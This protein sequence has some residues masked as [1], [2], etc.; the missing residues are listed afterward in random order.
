MAKHFHCPIND[1]ECPYFK[2]EPENNHRCICSLPD[3]MTDC[4][5][6]AYAWAGSEPEEYTDDHD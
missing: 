5:G 3:P 4:D 1:W 2:D 6:F